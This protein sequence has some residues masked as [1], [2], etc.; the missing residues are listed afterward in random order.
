MSQAFFAWNS[1]TEIW[2]IPRY[3]SQHVYP[4]NLVDN[5]MRGRSRSQIPNSR[6]C[7]VIFA[8]TVLLLKESFL[9]APIRQNTILTPLPFF[10]L[11]C[12]LFLSPPPFWHFSINKIIQHLK[13][14]QKSSFS[15]FLTDFFKATLQTK[16]LIFFHKI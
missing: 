11:T 4:F 15:K 10:F 6:S 3:W 7:L 8:S 13:L 16:T 1:Y 9:F 5:V 2:Q 12:N 14:V